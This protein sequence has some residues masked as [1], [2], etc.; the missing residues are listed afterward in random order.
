[1][2]SYFASC[3]APG[4]YEGSLKEIYVPIAGDLQEPLSMMSHNCCSK[5]I[6]YPIP[7]TE[8]KFRLEILIHDVSIT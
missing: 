7:E 6:P 3:R 5:K 1:M 8:I 4:G 2:F